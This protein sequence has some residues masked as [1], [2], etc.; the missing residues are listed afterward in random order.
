ML[1]DVLVH[2][3]FGFG[4]QLP[5]RRMPKFVASAIRPAC[6]LPKFISSSADSLLD[7]AHDRAP[8]ERVGAGR[9]A[10]NSDANEA[11]SSDPTDRAK[12]TPRQGSKLAQ[13]I[14]LLKRSDGATITNLIDATEWPSICSNHE[15]PAR[16][17]TT[18]LDASRARS[19]SKPQGSPPDGLG[20]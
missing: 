13:V 9:E 11:S 12:T 17:R 14:D 15:V 1:F 19:L 18:S 6:V 10:N 5:S 20:A 16:R 4:V 8:R 7:V 2:R 3:N